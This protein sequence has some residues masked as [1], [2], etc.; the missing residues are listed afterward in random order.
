MVETYKDRR[1]VNHRN[2]NNHVKSYQLHTF[3]NYCD[4]PVEIVTLAEFTTVSNSNMLCSEIVALHR[5]AVRLGEP[6]RRIGSHST[7]SR[8]LDENHARPTLLLSVV[9]QETEQVTT[10]TSY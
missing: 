1:A 6:L 7:A 4:W 2:P 9:T 3:V 10:V 5:P 8:L